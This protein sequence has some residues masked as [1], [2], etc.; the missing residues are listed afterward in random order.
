[1]LL[2]AGRTLLPAGR[3]RLWSLDLGGEIISSHLALV[4]GQEYAYWLSG[5]DE[6]HAR[7]SPSLLGAL[8]VVED[9]FASGADRL[10]LGLGDYGYKARFADGADTQ[11]YLRIVPRGRRYPL[12]RARVAPG[13]LRFAAEQAIDRHRRMRARRRGAQA[14]P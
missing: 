2:D 12:A 8:A 4:A 14:R 13:Q 7:V 9:A 5:F 3:F 11:E 6:R 10:D 1:M